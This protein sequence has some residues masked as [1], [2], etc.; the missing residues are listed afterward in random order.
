MISEMSLQDFLKMK[1][2]KIEKNDFDEIVRRRSMRPVKSL[3]S[4]VWG[5]ADHSVR[6]KSG[7]K[8][9]AESMYRQ[10]ESFSRICDSVYINS[11]A[12][13][14]LIYELMVAEW[15]IY[16]FTIWENQFGNNRKST[17]LWFNDLLR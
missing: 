8:A 6:L 12:T 15:E 11:Q 3:L 4:D 14:G 17:M 2:E 16:D 7:G 1:S 13:K 9:D 5:E 10:L